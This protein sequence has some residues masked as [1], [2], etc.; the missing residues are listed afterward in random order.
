MRKGIRYVLLL[1]SY[2]VQARA[3]SHHSGNGLVSISG[4]IIETPCSINTGD[5]KQTI[6][7]G[8]MPRGVITRDG[9]SVGK[10]FSIQLLHCQVSRIGNKLH[11]RQSFRVTFD[12]KNERGLFGIDGTAKGV[13][14][15][16]TDAEGHIAYPGTPQPKIPIKNGNIRLNYIFHLAEN[17]SDFRAGEYTTSIRFKIDYD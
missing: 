1:L 13:G 3:S 15:Q 14:L 12:G 8:V 16:L 7:I 10:P 17:G 2:C 6:D 4:S 11:T 9:H 5:S